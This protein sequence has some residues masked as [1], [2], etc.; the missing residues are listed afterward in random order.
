M[1]LIW[2]IIIAFFLFGCS[3]MGKP[4]AAPHLNYNTPTEQESKA[5]TNAAQEQYNKQYSL[6]IKQFQAILIKNPD[7]AIAL[8]GLA[9]SYYSLGIFKKCLYCSTHNTEYKTPF[10]TNIH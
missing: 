9:S 4:P 2:N 10:L 6:A 7:N 3:G 5:L 1:K 8:Y